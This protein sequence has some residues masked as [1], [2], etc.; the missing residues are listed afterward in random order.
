[1][2]PVI[3]SKVGHFIE[4]ALKYRQAEDSATRDF[5]TGLPNARA[6]SMHLDQEPARC[7]REHSAVAVS[8]CD[9]N[10]FKEVNDRYGHLAGDKVLKIFASSMRDLCREYDYTAHMGGD[11]F[12]I[13]A[14]N[15]TAEAVKE[16]AMVL[17]AMA[18]RASREVCDKEILSISLGVAFYPHDGLDAEQLLSE[19]DRRMYKAKQT[20]YGSARFASSD[21][22][23]PSFNYF[24]EQT[25]VGAVN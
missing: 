22:N 7:R 5:L 19:A 23:R 1:M 25:L 10:S 17:N 8:E 9:L 13:L 24:D 18:M 11:E 2:L 20:H 16:R 3:K 12:L 15:M 4:N 14:P 6:L 21:K